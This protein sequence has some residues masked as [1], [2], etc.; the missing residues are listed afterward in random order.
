MC[1]LANTLLI[2]VSYLDENTNRLYC[3]FIDCCSMG[4][5][6]LWMSVF[7][8]AKPSKS[9]VDSRLRLASF[10]HNNY[11][12]RGMGCSPRLQL[13]FHEVAD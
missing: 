11:S 3:W 9:Q 7:I 4:C 2:S 6:Y 12:Y 10:S 13:C 8:V 1:L 5:S